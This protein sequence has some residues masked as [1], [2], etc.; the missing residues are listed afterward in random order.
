MVRASSLR[1]LSSPS[2]ASLKSPDTPSVWK[3]SLTT[4]LQKLSIVHML[5]LYISC[6]C[7]KSRGLYGSSSRSFVISSVSRCFISAA[8]ALVNVTIKS[9]STSTGFSLL[10]ISL[11]TR[12]T[13]TAVLP[14]PAAAETSTEPPV[15]VIA[16][17]CAGVQFLDITHPP[18]F[19]VHP[20]VFRI[21]YHS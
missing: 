13:S 15:A 4:E 5:V 6:F 18:P 16:S 12:S 17:C 3:Y 8:A 14:E 7:L 2:S 20:Q 11:I 21:P 19:S 10:V 9:R 1:I